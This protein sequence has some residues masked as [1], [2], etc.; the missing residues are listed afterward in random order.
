M[1][2]GKRGSRKD[3]DQPQDL[4][5]TRIRYT[6]PRSALETSGEV[7]DFDIVRAAPDEQ[8]QFL[9]SLSHRQETPAEPRKPRLAAASEAGVEERPN[10][11]A[12]EDTLCITL[13]E[14][15]AERMKNLDVGVPAYKVKRL[16]A[17]GGM[18]AVFEAYHRETNARVAIKIIRSDLVT[19]MEAVQRFDAE[20]EAVSRVHH[21]NIVRLVEYGRNQ[22]GQRYMITEFAEGE[23]LAK[24]LEDGKPLS[25]KH[26]LQTGEQIAGALLAAHKQG[27][28]HRDLKPENL[29]VLDTD[30][31]GIQV[32]LVDFGLARLFSGAPSEERTT[33]GQIMGTPKY[34][35][36]EQAWG[37]SETDGRSDIYS[38]AC[39]LFHAITGRA[40]FTGSA[41][42]VMHCHRQEAPPTL[43]QINPKIPSELSSFLGQMMAKLPEQRPMLSHVESTFAALSRSYFPKFD[44]SPNAVTARRSEHSKAK[45]FTLRIEKT[46]IKHENRFRKSDY[47]LAVGATVF[48]LTLGSA[49]LIFQSLL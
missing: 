24:L 12:F 49:W 34:M 38:L 36:P 29:I 15:S 9:V 46:S 48:A 40:P 25:A 27:I 8:T 2:V 44:R 30:D 41:I 13:P 7:D 33:L 18:G 26:A 10:G 1:V 19:S 32:K 16:I 20:V 39:V 23:T 5:Q 4:E 37:D 47:T 35:S 14:Q 45:R 17:S 6:A 42:E 31:G 21:P 28:V 11:A 3:Q 43:N 22:H